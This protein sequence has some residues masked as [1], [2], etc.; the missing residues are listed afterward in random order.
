[1]VERMYSE[2]EASNKM[3]LLALV[4]DKLEMAVEIY[5]SN[6]EL[7]YANSMAEAVRAPPGVGGAEKAAAPQGGA[8][9]RRRRGSHRR[10]D[11]G[12]CRRRCLSA[13][14]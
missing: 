3:K 14:G 4:L 8:E 5:G 9:E 1:M 6:F 12:D 13:D 11:R 10:Q 7:Q 2:A